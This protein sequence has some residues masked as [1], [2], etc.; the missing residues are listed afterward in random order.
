MSVNQTASPEVVNDDEFDYDNLDPKSLMINSTSEES[1]ILFH[2]YYG[3]IEMST[4]SGTVDKCEQTDPILI[5]TSCSVSDFLN[6][7]SSSSQTENREEACSC[8]HNKQKT[9]QVDAEVQ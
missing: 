2:D 9:K 8:Y 7:S 1:P 4:I 5:P 6:L 3:Q